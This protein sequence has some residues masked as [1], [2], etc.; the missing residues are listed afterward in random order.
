MVLLCSCGGKRYLGWLEAFD[1]LPQA[2]KEV[3]VRV[4]HV[5][6][7]WPSGNV[8]RAHLFRALCRVA[9]LAGSLGL[10]LWGVVLT[11]EWNHDPGTNLRL[12]KDNNHMW[13]P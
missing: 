11:S 12:E 3:E 7:G 9:E 8:K 13:T 4:S 10:N 1:P 5:S 6:E 2:Q